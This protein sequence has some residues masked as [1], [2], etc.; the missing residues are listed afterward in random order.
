MLILRVLTALVFAPALLF[1]LWEGG[2][3]LRWACVVL[4]LLL[5]W[6]MQRMFSQVLGVSG[7]L[8]V[9]A[10]ALLM[11]G[12][13]LLPQAY[14]AFGDGVIVLLLAAG[15]GVVWQPLPLDRAAERLGLMVTAAFY[16]GAL[17]TQVWMLRQLPHGL[18]LALLGVFGTWAS[19]TGAYFIGHAIGKI[20]LSPTISPNKTL[21]GALGGAL[22]TVTLALIL[23]MALHLPWS[24]STVTLLALW[25]S[26]TSVMGDLVAS[27]LK[28]SAGVKDSSGLIPGHGG[29]LDRFDGILFAAPALLLASRWLL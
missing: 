4:A 5:S 2:S 7:R 14:S 8:I 10:G 6:E 12:L 19:D 18:G 22:V 29:V 23:R 21:E 11:A 26:A 24:V 13:V 9:M 20:P 27:L 15:A 25:V 3:A 1:C 16:C 17:I 28:R